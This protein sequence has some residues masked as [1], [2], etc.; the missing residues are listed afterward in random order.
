MK[1]W[2]ILKKYCRAQNW[3]KF[4]ALVGLNWE[5]LASQ[6][7]IKIS[8]DAWQTV[9]EISGTLSSPFWC[10]FAADQRQ[11]WSVLIHF[12]CPRKRALFD[13]LQGKQSQT[14]RRASGRIR[15]PSPSRL[16]LRA[17]TSSAPGRAPRRS[18]SQS[19]SGRI[20]TK[21]SCPIFS[22]PSNKTYKS[23]KRKQTKLTF[24]VK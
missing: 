18:A 1:P 21:N 14:E 24:H 20:F 8:C 3:N 5:C 6:P 23:G 4:R 10:Q 16:P 2:E 22:S 7:Q 15:W 11:L 13:L 19:S 17:D 12:R 9:S